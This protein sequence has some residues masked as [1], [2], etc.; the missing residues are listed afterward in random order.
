MSGRH[1]AAG[2][3]NRLPSGRCWTRR[4]ASGW[5]AV[6]SLVHEA[7]E[8]RERPLVLAIAFHSGLAMICSAKPCYSTSG[9]SLSF[10]GIRSARSELGASADCGG[11][12]R[13]R[14]ASSR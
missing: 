11:E 12:T 13:L 5:F 8:L 6:E 14:L 1:G 4:A 9:R 7:A 10:E 3:G 2:N